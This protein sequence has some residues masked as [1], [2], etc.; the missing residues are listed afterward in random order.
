MKWVSVNLYLMKGNCIFIQ[1]DSVLLKDVYKRQNSNRSPMTKT[2][3][4]LKRSRQTA[5]I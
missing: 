4:F 5:H 1:R 2:G 3:D